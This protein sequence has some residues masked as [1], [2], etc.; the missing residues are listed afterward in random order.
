MNVNYVTV[1]C[2]NCPEGDC[3]YNKS[4]CK[5]ILYGWV[6]KAG[7]IFIKEQLRGYFIFQEYPDKWWNY[8][9]HFD[10]YCSETTQQN[11]L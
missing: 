2:K 8:M 10:E 6:E 3:F 9:D 4:F 5:K 11:Y 1:P 7:Q